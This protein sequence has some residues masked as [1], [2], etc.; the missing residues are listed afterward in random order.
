MKLFHIQIVYESYMQI[1]KD[2]YLNFYSFFLEF[3]HQ[4][5]TDVKFSESGS[6]NRREE[7]AACMF[8]I[9]FMDD[10]EEGT[11]YSCLFSFE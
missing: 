9:N 6:S 2:Q 5:F 10:S 8:F 4:L 1:C 11:I 3:L 7:E